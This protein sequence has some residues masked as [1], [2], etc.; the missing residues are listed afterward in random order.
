MHELGLLSGVAAAVNRAARG[1]TVT[2]VNLT[3][4]QRSGAVVS[5]L[6][7]AWPLAR[8]GPSEHA[9]LNITSVAATVF[10]PGCD[11]EVPIDDYFALQCPDCGTPTADLRHGREFLV[12]SIEVDVP[13]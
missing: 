7:A 12:D 2:A 6:E 13:D 4:G 1:R 5:A 10:C 8:C 11:T 3:V 9:E